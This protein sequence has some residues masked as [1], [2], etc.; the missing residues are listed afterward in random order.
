MG[1]YIVKGLSAYREERCIM[2]GLIHMIQNTCYARIVIGRPYKL[3]DCSSHK[4]NKAWRNLKVQK[5]MTDES[6]REV[7]FKR[8]G[9]TRIA[10][11]LKVESDAIKPLG[12][13]VV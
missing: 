11:W 3:F 9:G 12:D 4:E 1:K 10:G 6:Y 8:I 13:E 7:S 5:P 2:G